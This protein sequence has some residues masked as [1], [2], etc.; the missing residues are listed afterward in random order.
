[1]TLCYMAVKK[2]LKQLDV[3]RT[4]VFMWRMANGTQMTEVL[5]SFLTYATPEW[6]HVKPHH[7]GSNSKGTCAKAACRLAYHLKPSYT[8]AYIHIR[9]SRTLLQTFKDTRA[10]V[11]LCISAAKYLAFFTS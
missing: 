1:M 6:R 9:A 4:Y 8:H 7:S 2:I 5:S 11:L 3:F 10:F